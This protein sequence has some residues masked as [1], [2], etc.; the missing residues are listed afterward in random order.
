MS[1]LLCLIDL[2]VKLLGKRE[3]NECLVHWRV[4]KG[5]NLTP[6]GNQFSGARVPMP[7]KS[8]SVGQISDVVV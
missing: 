4:R 3:S 7:M 8:S 1:E 5:R 2:D 6:I